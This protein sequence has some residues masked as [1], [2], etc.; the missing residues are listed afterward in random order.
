MESKHADLPAFK[1][2]LLA[3]ALCTPLETLTTSRGEY[4]KI[5][6]F[7]TLERGSVAPINTSPIF[8][9]D[10]ARVVTASFV[11]IGFTSVMTFCGIYKAEELLK[12]F[13]PEIIAGTPVAKGM[14]TAY[15]AFLIQPFNMPFINFQTTVLKNPQ[16]ELKAT[17]KAFITE[18]APFAGS[19]GRSIY[20]AAFYGLTFF[21]TETMKNRDH[22]TTKENSID[23]KPPV[24]A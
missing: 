10:F 16:R 19:L 4:R 22:K 2:G 17:A 7:A 9:R 13:V 8:T 24:L 12:P 6:S 21:I 14:I 23:I 20:R 3:A 11:R 15:A 1:K 5:Q 18:Q